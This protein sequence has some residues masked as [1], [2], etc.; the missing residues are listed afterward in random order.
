MLFGF[1]CRFTR[2]CWFLC[3]W[4]SKAT[5]KHFFFKSRE[6]KCKILGFNQHRT[7]DF[8]YSPHK[9]RHKE[10]FY[11]SA[12]Y[13]SLRIQYLK[14]IFPKLCDAKL[15]TGIF[16]SSQIGI[17]IKNNTFDHKLNDEDLCERTSLKAMI[18]VFQAIVS[19]ENAELVNDLLIDFK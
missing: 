16:I 3:M 9:T 6:V 19:P 13:K 17:L 12:G 7:R 10:Q 18:N 4:D 5:V 1:Q 14:Y 2:Y 11:E 15:K 8:I